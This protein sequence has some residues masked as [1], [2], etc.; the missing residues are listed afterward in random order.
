MTPE[1]FADRVA[2]AVL[3]GERDYAAEPVVEVVYDDE[4]DC[5]PDDCDC[6]ADPGLPF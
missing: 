5:A 6:D 3:G 2:A 1:Q 4:C